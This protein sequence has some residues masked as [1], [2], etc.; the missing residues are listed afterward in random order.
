MIVEQAGGAASTGRSRLLDVVP[1]GLHERV[2]VIL[3]SRREV[4]RLVRYH[5]DHDG[6]RDRPYTNPLFNSR[7]LFRGA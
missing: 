7:S 6:G 4:E 5:A 3:G 1:R 2:A